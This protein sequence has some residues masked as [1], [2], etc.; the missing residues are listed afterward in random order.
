MLMLI[1]TLMI[2]LILD[3]AK[4]LLPIPLYTTIISILV[5]SLVS[6]SIRSNI[7]IRISYDLVSPSISILKTSRIKARIAFVASE[8]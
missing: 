2:F 6:T 5:I 8:L 4:I 7:L 1:L 3:E